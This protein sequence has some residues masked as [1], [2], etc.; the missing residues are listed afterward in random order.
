MWPTFRESFPAY[1]MLCFR[2]TAIEGLQ[3]TL[4][5]KEN[6]ENRRRIM[7]HFYSG[8]SQTEEG[9]LAKITVS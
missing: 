2:Y 3:K 7:M 1:L 4:Q 6:F 5:V 9:F 8:S